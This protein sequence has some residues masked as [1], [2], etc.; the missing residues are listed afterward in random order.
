MFNL[1]EFEKYKQHLLAGKILAY[2]T[3]TVWG[4]GVLPSDTKAIEKL[5][6]LKS[7]KKNQS[8]SLLVSDI[9]MAEKLVHINSFTKKAL[10]IL[11][12]GPVT[13]VLKAKD[14]NISKNIGGKGFVGLR[15]SNHNF[16]KQLMLHLGEPLITTSANENGK[17]PAKKWNDLNWIDKQAS[18][19][20]IEVLKVDEKFCSSQISCISSTVIKIEETLEKSVEH[21]CLEH[22]PSQNKNLISILRQGELTQ[23]QID[24]IFKI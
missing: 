21:K 19:K 15:C 22:K 1:E 17:P 5:D 7:R 10:Q 4:L 16:V 12:P 14:Q 11:W 24:K 13:L 3:E 20:D 2:P 6:Q 8:Y 9:K 18:V 23:E